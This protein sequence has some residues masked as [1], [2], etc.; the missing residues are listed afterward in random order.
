MTDTVRA[1][2]AATAQ[3]P[4]VIDLADSRIDP[5]HNVN[6]GA[7]QGTAGNGADPFY[8]ASDIKPKRSRRTK[9][10][11]VALRAAIKGLLEKDHPQT[12]RQIFYALT[13]RGLI[14][15]RERIP[16]DRRS[17]SRRDAREEGDPVRLDRGPH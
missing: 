9:P 17:P 1:P 7:G 6:A 10:E 5:E 8:I 14:Q 12:V 2:A 3:G 4:R 13:V 11:V 15:K 16:A